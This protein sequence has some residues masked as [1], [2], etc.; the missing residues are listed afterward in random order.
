MYNIDK[1]EHEVHDIETYV[2]EIEENDDFDRKPEKMRWSM[3][4]CQCQRVRYSGLHPIR[5]N[6]CI[7]ERRKAGLS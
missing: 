5:K 6:A 2:A 1:N 4:T 7:F 3:Q